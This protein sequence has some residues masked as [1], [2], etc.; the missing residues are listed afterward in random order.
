M[1]FSNVIKRITT[2]FNTLRRFHFNR[3]VYNNVR[4][5]FKLNLNASTY[6]F[7]FAQSTKFLTELATDA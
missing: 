4:L 6:Q 7:G 1:P 2:E 3:R 5:T